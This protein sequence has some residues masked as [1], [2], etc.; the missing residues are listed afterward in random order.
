MGEKENLKRISNFADLEI[1]GE[2]DKKKI[3]KKRKNIDR[4]LLYN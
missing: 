1:K 2:N 4:T 3:R